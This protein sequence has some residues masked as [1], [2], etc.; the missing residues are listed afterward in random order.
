MTYALLLSPARR[1]VGGLCL[2]SIF[3]VLGCSGEAEEG[4]QLANRRQEIKGGTVDST[5]KFVVLLIS[6]SGPGG[7]CTGTLIAPNLVL[8]AQHCVADIPAVAGV[9]SGSIDCDRSKFGPK[10]PAGSLY[11]TTD[12]TFSQNS[13]NFI[14]VREVIVPPGSNNVCGNDIALLILSNNIPASVAT[15]IFPRLDTAPTRGE[16]YT[17]IGYGHIGDARQSGSGTRRRLENLSV[18]CVGSACP[19][20]AQVNTTELLGSDGTCQGDSGGG[21]FDSAGRVFGALSR[22]YGNCQGSTYSGTYRWASWIRDAGRRAAQLGG[23]SAPAWVGGDSSPADFDLDGIP[24]A[25]D[26]CPEVSNSNQL[27][28]DRDGTGDACD[29]DVDGDGVDDHSDNCPFVVNRDQRDT[30]GDTVGDACDND[31]DGDFVDNARDNC[32]FVANPDQADLDSDGVGDVCDEDADGDGVLNAMD[33]CPT[34]SNA[35]QNP[36]A[37]GGMDPHTNHD[38]DTDPQD[39][40]IPGDNTEEDPVVV[41]QVPSPTS[42]GHSSCAVANPAGPQ[43]T[44]LALL[45]GLGLGMVSFASWRRKLIG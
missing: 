7:L 2:I 40:V 26:N 3:S 41:R 18:Q 23:Y 12:T 1:I 45:F 28:M 16:R 27:D 36:A 15:P 29:D 24:D 6:V 34:V 5:S 37:C 17:A 9:P 31:P 25:R 21:A 20:Y 14:G 42:T 8:T 19:Y 4:I 10:T 35:D 32:A 44:T 43:P 30:D 39:P 38:P 33:N 22:G 11:I 13:R